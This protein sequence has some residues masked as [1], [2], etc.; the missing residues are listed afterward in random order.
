MALHKLEAR[1]ED[2]GKDQDEEVTI[3]PMDFEG[4]PVLD[5]MIVIEDSP[6]DG[7]GFAD[8]FRGR[9]KVPREM[10]APELLA[11]KVFRFAWLSPNEGEGKVC[12]ARVIHSSYFTLLCDGEWNANALWR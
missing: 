1:P 2:E 11:V 5:G 9:W 3:S 8:V 10:D 4:I 12:Q 6:A 7:G